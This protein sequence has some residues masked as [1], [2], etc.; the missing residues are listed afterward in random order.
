LA[1]DITRNARHAAKVL[2]KFKLLEWQSKELSVVN[3]WMQK[4]PLFTAIAKQLN[5]TLD[6]LILWLPPAL[7][8]AGGAKLIG[9]LLINVD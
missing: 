9:Q 7:C 3:A 8:K 5:L 2:L 1:S 4:T 6:E